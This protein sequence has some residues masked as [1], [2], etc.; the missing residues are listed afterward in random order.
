MLRALVLPRRGFFSCV[1]AMPQYL[2]FASSQWNQPVASHV[3]GADP[4]ASP[5][6]VRN[7]VQKKL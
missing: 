1:A 3:F 6:A 5:I 7:P 2:E 4:G